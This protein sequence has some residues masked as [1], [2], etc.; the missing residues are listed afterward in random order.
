MW[1][2]EINDSNVIRDGRKKLEIPCHRIL[3]L[4]V[5]QYYVI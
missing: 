5:K 1:V 2:N 3:A 4:H